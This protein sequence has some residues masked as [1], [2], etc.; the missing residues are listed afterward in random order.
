LELVWKGVHTGP[1]QMPNGT[2]PA[3]NKRIEIPVCQIV[4]VEDGKI[5]S[6]THYFDMVT[7]LSQI[8]AFKG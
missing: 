3:S 2:I 4:K 7:L 6:V 5:R 1:L 8:G